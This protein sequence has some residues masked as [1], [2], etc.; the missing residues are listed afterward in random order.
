MSDK[1]EEIR[2]RHEAG[3]RGSAVEDREWLL[4]EAERLREE[5]S[6]LRASLKIDFE[7]ALKRAEGDR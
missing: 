7:A 5:N 6:I 4:D 3:E 2:E 1:I